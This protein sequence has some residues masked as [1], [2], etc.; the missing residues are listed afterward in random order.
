MTT[1]EFPSLLK[2]SDVRPRLK[3]D[4]LNKEILKNCRPVANIPFLT[5]GIEK[6]VTTQTYN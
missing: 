5:K 4:N 6:A 3:K 1:G 2:L